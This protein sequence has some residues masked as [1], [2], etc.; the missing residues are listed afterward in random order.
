M[1]ETSSKKIRAGRQIRPRV[2]VAKIIRLDCAIK[3]FAGLTV[4]TSFSV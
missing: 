2:N 4:R 3:I 1:S